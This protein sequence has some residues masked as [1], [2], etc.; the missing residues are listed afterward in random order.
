MCVYVG[1]EELVANAFIEL[2]DNTATREIL[3]SQLNEYGSRVIKLLHDEGKNAVLVL[4]TKETDSFL[5]NYSDYFETF[6]SKNGKGVKLKKGK[7][8]DDLWK[9]FRGYL[10]FDVM[11]AFMDKNSVAAL[12]IRKSTIF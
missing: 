12:G 9:K 11:K 10:A 5:N 4:S 1:I 8:A 3:F 7:S 2:V 6:S